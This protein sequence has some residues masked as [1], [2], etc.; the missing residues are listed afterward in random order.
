MITMFLEDHPQSWRAAVTP[1]SPCHAPTR[2]PAAPPSSRRHHS[3]PLSRLGHVVTPLPVSRLGH[4]VTTHSRCHALVTRSL[5]MR[6]E[7]RCAATPDARPV[8]TRAHSRSAPSPDTR[9]LPMRAE[10]RCAATPDARPVPTRASLSMRAE[11]RSAATPDARPVPTR[12]HSRDAPRPQGRP[13]RSKSRDAPRLQGR[14]VTHVNLH[15]G[16]KLQTLPQNRDPDKT[17]SGTR[18]DLPPYSTLCG[19][20]QAPPSHV[21]EVTMITMFLEDHPQS[22]RAAVTPSSPCHAPTRPPAAP[23]S[24]RRHHSLPLSRLGHVVTPLPVSRLGHGVTTHSRCHA[25]V[26]RSLPMRAESRCAATPDAR[27][28]PTRAHSRS[29]PSPDTRSLPMRAESRCAATPDARPVPTRASLSMRAES[30]SAATPDARPVP[31]RAHS[32]DAPRP[33]GRPSRSK[34]RDAPRL[35]GRA[36]T[37]VNLHPGVKL[38]TLPQNRDPDKTS[39]GTRRDL[40]PYST[41]C[42]I[43]QAPPSH[44]KEVTMITMFLEDH[45]QS[46]RAAVTPSSPCHAP[47][48]PPAAPPS[49]RRH[50]SLPLSRLGHVVTPLP[51]SRLGHGV[52]THSRCHALVTRSLPMRAESRCAATPDARPVPTRAHSRSAPSPD[53]RSLPMRAE[54]RCAATPDARP[55]PT[56]AR[57]RHALTPDARP[58]PKELALRKEIFLI[59]LP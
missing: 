52:T 44:V 32:R 26:T 34:S 23:P 18:R 36:V 7:S 28:V 4:G 13:S 48:R 6:A 49:S 25:L 35:Q 10:S 17:S 56:R 20:R 41:L 55:V 29:A 11:S 54:S 59:S 47:T 16:V 3:L 53:T 22:W 14:A 15:P 42:G 40:P 2:P 50:H 5:P 24:S 1:S 30:R 8:P 9:S 31:T 58:V 27:P 21:K 43:R 33:Q 45:P 12:A 37:H 46:W 38:Q 51:V 39:S 19:I 57:S